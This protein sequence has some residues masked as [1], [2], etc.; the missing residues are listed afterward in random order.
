MSR[1][2]KAPVEIVSGVEVSIAG[3]ESQLK[4]K[5]VH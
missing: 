2:A 1:V 3:Q 5:T 4:V